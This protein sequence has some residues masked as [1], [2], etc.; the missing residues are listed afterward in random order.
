MTPWVFDI[1]QDTPDEY[2]LCERLGPE[3]CRSHLETHWASDWFNRDVVFQLKEVGINALRI[4]V[5]FWAFDNA[6]TPYVQGSAEWFDKAIGWAREAGMKVW[7]DLH[8][9][10]GSQ[11]G[12]DNSGHAGPVEWQQGGNI[13]RTR[14]V[15]KMMAERYGTQEYADVVA[16]IQLINEPI[17]WGEFSRLCT[18]GQLLTE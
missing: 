5:G 12:F 7:V 14:S 2:T 3:A 13:E 4:P 17:S 8:G 18:R 16:A 6:N 11:N 1:A 10:P 15:L 9:A